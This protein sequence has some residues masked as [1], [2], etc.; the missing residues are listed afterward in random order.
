MTKV[1][2]SGTEVLVAQVAT[3]LRSRGADV[4]E[5]PD[6]DDV[7]AACAA[8]GPRAFDSYVQLPATFRVRGSTAVRRVH[9]FY[10]EGVLARFTALAAALP[11]LAVGARLTFV[12]GQLPVEA[13]TADDRAARRALTQVLAHAALADMPDGR[14]T[15]RMLNA[16]TSPEEIAQVALGEDPAKRELIDQLSQLSYADWRVELLGLASVET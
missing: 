3:A 7:A 4:V 10:A 8:A 2:V 14:L 5:V 16:G 6:L 9:H 12:M 13:A 1:L 15:V 11:S